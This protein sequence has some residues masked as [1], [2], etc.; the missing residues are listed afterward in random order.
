MRYSA[1]PLSGCSC[2]RPFCP[3]PPS[4][5]VI[6]QLYAR[7]LS[8]KA[9]KRLPDSM[10][11][12]EYYRILR[13]NRRGSRFVG[14]DDGALVHDRPR[15]RELIDRPPKKLKGEVRTLVLLVDFPDRPHLPDR[16]PG[17]F[18]QMLFSE[19]HAMP[20]GSMRDYYRAISGWNNSGSH[21]IDVTGEV[22]G[23]FRL[24]QPLAYYSDSSS[25]MDGSY[26]RNA[27][28]M[29]RDAVRAALD[30]NVDF[31]GFDA[32]GEGLITALFVIHAGRGAESTWDRNDIWSHKWVIPESVRVAPN[33]EARTYLTVPED[34]RVGV[35]AHEWGHL[36]ARWADYYDTGTVD[37]ARSNGLGD[38]CL[39]A[40]GSWGD[41]G[42]TPTLPNGMLRMFHG[43]I[44]PE[45][46]D[47][48][49]NDIILKP[50]AEGG[51]VVI[52]RNPE[53][54][55]DSQYVVVEYRRRRGQDAFL[56]DEGLAIYVVDE[57]IKDVNNER[58]LAI[59]LM[60][61]DNRRDLAKV[62]GQGNRGDA[63]D[64]YPSNKNRQLG[65]TTSPPL[66]LPGGKWTGITISVKG[67][68][69]DPE[70][71]IDVTIATT[72]A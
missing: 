54:M 26:P 21:G 35:C 9:E 46:I 60:Q 67:E 47:Q 32:L 31:S 17:S 8:L 57:E 71:S 25:G 41:G 18:E 20:A 45:V 58:K 13:S 72:G 10:S 48:S 42:L 23:W 2:V 68:P 37:N 29:A 22:R 14:L 24:P 11:F 69:G 55:T 70:M 6:A 66:N 53:L 34:C 39:M 15:A 44:A 65:K 59:E 56:P 4:P 49:R 3:V 52:V 36:A 16:S 30:A 38:Y 40:S 28:G 27:Q 33:I 43:W 63:D 19:G 62:F 51:S 7:F 12:A 50:A 64:L 1:T 61:A 5:E